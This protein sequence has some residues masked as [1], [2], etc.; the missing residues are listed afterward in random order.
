MDPD[1]MVRASGERVLLEGKKG[2]TLGA[3]DKRSTA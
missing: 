1:A 3:A 2:T